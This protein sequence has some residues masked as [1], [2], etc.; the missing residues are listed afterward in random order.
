[1]ATNASSQIHSIESL[2]RIY[3]IQSQKLIFHEKIELAEK[4]NAKSDPE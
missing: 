4:V 3:Q 1:M 2:A